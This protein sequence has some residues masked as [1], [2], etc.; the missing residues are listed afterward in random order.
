MFP[1]DQRE[2]LLVLE[3][4]NTHLHTEL[5]QLRAEVSALKHAG[6][7]SHAV[8]NGVTSEESDDNKTDEGQIGESAIIVQKLVTTESVPR[9]F[10]ET[11]EK[12]KKDNEA[13][14]TENSLLTEELESLRDTYNKLVIAGDN[15]QDIYD[16]L[17]LEKEEI[18]ADLEKVATEKQDLVK[19]NEYLLS[20]GNAMHD[21]IEKLVLE[22]EKLHDQNQA[23]VKEKEEV[24]KQLAAVHVAGKASDIAALL[25]ERDK[26]KSQVEE[27]ENE[28][29]KIRHDHA[30]V[31]EEV[32]S[33][34]AAYGRLEYEKDQIQQEFDSLQDEFEAVQQQHD[35]LQQDYGQ[36]EQ[37]YSELLADKEK[38]E[39]EFLEVQTASVQV[40][41]QNPAILEEKD[42]LQHENG[43]LLMEKEQ[44]EMTINELSKSNALLNEELSSLKEALKLKEGNQETPD[45]KAPYSPKESRESATDLVVEKDRRIRSLQIQISRLQQQLAVGF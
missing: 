34:Q 42:K 12:V 31:L 30:I 3:Q 17:V 2:N 16:Q 45:A 20:D 1:E 4:E 43:V 37:D 44:L 33:L 21:D 39:Q 14:R 36:L 32:Q 40:E 25:E 15:L 19:E 27:Y 23:I 10:D 8:V 26:L 11:D 9:N 41:Q 5:K 24:E 35:G 28:M 29:D 13:L 38:L 18:H 7:T 6:K 22:V